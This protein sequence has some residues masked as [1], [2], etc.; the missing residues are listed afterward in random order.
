MNRENLWLANAKP[1]TFI[2]TENYT[3]I[4]LITDRTIYESIVQVFPPSQCD[5]KLHYWFD[6]KE[7]IKQL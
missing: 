1:G 5:G 3:K 7:T 4:F 2:K 6:L